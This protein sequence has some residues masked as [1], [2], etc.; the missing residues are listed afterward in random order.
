MKKLT[1]IILFCILSII[2]TKNMFSQ[3][4]GLV[5]DSKKL[6]PLPNANVFLEKTKYGTTTDKNG[7]FIIKNIPE[8]I[9]LLHISYIGYKPIIQKIN[10]QNSRKYYKK[11]LLEQKTMNINNIVITATKMPVEIQNLTSDVEIITKDKIEIETGGNIS[12]ALKYAGG[13]YI[14]NYGARGNIKAISIRGSSSQQVLFLLDGIRI[15]NPQSGN[16]D[17]S[18]FLLTSFSRIELVKGGMSSLYG[19]DAIGG[20]IN[21]ITSEENSSDKSNIICEITSGSFGFN[22]FNL[23]LIKNSKKRFLKFNFNHI[24]GDGNFHFIK[25]EK[26]LTRKNAQFKISNWLFKSIYRAKDN[27]NISFISFGYTSKKGVPGSIVSPTLKA[28][29]NDSQN[30]I[31]LKIN[32]KI[33]HKL[34]QDVNIFYQNNSF[35]YSDPELNNDKLVNKYN[36]NTAGINTE[37]N[38]ILSKNLSTVIGGEFYNTLLRSNTLEKTSRK[39]FAI[40]LMNRYNHHTNLSILPDFICDTSLR[41]DKFTGYKSILSYGAGFSLK[42]K[43]LLIRGNIHKNIRIPTFN[44]LYWPEDSFTK[45]NP[46]LKPEKSFSEDIGI[47]IKVSEP[48]EFHL[49]ATFF[50]ILY[51]DLIN[52]QPDLSGKWTPV[53]IGKANSR[54][55]EFSIAIPVI[56]NILNFSPPPLS[57]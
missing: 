35:K 3:I 49:G 15:N 45:G 25:D 43:K 44:D 30:N 33:S 2:F 57:G 26:K 52:W 48:V 16:I 53:N 4:S 6:K 51:Q 14:K 21:L 23:N 31:T 54:G 27:L 10:F 18:N 50:N 42:N 19:T 24:N 36:L 38:L 8:G 55:V 7:Y 56:K 9:Y 12:D 20:I 40:F 39:S 47:S 13:I 34:I 1:Q 5:L 37:N 17:L 46:E 22:S 29:I 28:N 32:H 41:I 11:Y